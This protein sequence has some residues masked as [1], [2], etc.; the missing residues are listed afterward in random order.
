LSGWLSGEGAGSWFVFGAEGTL[1]EVTRYSPQG[2]I[3]CKGLYENQ[4]TSD[5]LKDMGSLFI[6]YPSNCR[7][8]S[9]KDDTKKKVFIVLHK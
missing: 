5:F 2:V 1:L 7:M 6:T 4:H 8:V 9:I 3:E